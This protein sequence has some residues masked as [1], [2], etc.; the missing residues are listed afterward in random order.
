MAMTVCSLDRCWVFAGQKTNGHFNSQEFIR[1]D[2]SRHHENQRSL[3]YLLRTRWSIRPSFHPPIGSNSWF[4]CV[5]NTSSSY[6]LVA[7]IVYIDALQ[8]VFTWIFV[9]SFL[10]NHM[11]SS[12]N[13]IHFIGLS[14]QLISTSLLDFLQA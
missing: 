2:P 5:L 6:M 7:W 8:L 11:Q 13:S 4:S 9:F 14:F 10:V 1:S 3:G 12:H